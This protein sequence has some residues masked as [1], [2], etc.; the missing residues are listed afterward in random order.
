MQYLIRQI[1]KFCSIFLIVILNKFPIHGQTTNSYEIIEVRS[2]KT[3]YNLLQFNNKLYI[4]TSQGTIIIDNKSNKEDLDKELKGYLSIEKGKLIGN[5]SSFSHIIKEDENI[6]NYLL[7]ESYK[8]LI[9]RQNKYFGRLFIINS[10]KLFVFK[11]NNFTISHDSLSVRSI[12][13]NYIGSYKGI[14]KNGRK[15]KFP[16]YTDGYIREFGN[17]TIICYEGLH[18]DSASFSRTY[19]NSKKEVFFGGYNLG[20]ARDIQ[21]IKDGDYAFVS[22]KGIYIINFN[23]DKVITVFEENNIYDHYSIFK[24]DQIDKNKTRIFFTSQNKL[25]YY[26]VET[27]ERSLL[28]DTKNKNVIK[29]AYFPNTIDKIYILFEDKLSLFTLN[30][31]NFKYN[32]DVLMEGLVFSHNFIIYKEKVLVTTNV[33]LHMYDLKKNKSYM[34]I[35][36]YEVNNRSLAIIGDTVKFGTIN[37]IINLTEGN[38]ENIVKEFDEYA[39]IDKN[40][41]TFESKYYILFLVIISGLVITI[42]LLYISLK[43]T[44]S[45]L[46]TNKTKE[47]QSYGEANKENI[48]LYIQENITTVTIQSIRDQF[49]LTPV[50]L[51][52]ILG[53]DKPGELIR[54]YRMELVR[55]YRRIKLSEEDIAQKTG[56]SISY[57]KKIY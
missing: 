7:P 17:E 47:D 25:Y 10:G 33:G 19:A 42:I 26:V 20:F 56:F 53:N 48:I 38:I 1:V 50:M 12:T 21:K 15:I 14:F 8:N 55:K 27:K 36:P 39:T 13:P 16:E 2:D 4:G 5:S 6:Y 45:N 40:E 23:T 43:K 34:N 52:D 22:N 35:V 11:E 32:E 41:N 51:Y 37:G 18:R 28:L 31:I 3:Y 57:L 44:K 30:N 24:I 54:N 46:N 9:S 29:Q 49:N